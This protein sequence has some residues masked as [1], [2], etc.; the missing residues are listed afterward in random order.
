MWPDLGN[1]DSNPFCE[2]ASWC[3]PGWGLFLSFF[4]W[5]LAP[6]RLCYSDPHSLLPSRGQAATSKPPWR[7]ELGWVPVLPGAPPEAKS[8]AGRG[9][10][11]RRWGDPSRL[12]R[13]AG[14]WADLIGSDRCNRIS[15]IVIRTAGSPR[16]G[17]RPF[18]AT[19]GHSRD[20]PA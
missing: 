8:G 18:K 14:D 2:S 6:A 19:R 7:S 13:A 17:A 9:G 4:F 5:G 12:G 16:W 10:M 1:L 20:V 3:R 11:K 15:A